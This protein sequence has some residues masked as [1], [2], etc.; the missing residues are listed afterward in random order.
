[1]INVI[2]FTAIIAAFGLLLN[3][4]V[5]YLLLSQGKN[6][7][8]HLFA[9]ILV[10]NAIWD[11]GILASMLRNGYE[12]ELIVYGYISSLAC[13]FLL[14]LIFHFTCIYLGRS[15]VKTCL[16]LWFSAAEIALLMAAGKFGRISGVVQYSWGN[17]WQGD[18]A[19]HQTSL[20]GILVYWAMLAAASW[21]LYA[22]LKGS[23]NQDRRH[24]LLILV[25]FA[26]LVVAV[27]R[28]LPSMGVGWPYLLV[29]G[30]LVTDYFS[31]LIGI[32]ILKHTLF[33][34]DLRQRSIFQG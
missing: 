14:P 31:A 1:M 17:F 26:G 15:K 28:V 2:N 5:F 19:W 8:Q 11:L 9:V 22:R 20:I 25:G 13:V 4:T 3:L 12:G 34:Q 18:D 29:S 6:L 21:M 33:E 24:L 16:L 7:Y 30:I 27:T 23:E 32:S 10:I